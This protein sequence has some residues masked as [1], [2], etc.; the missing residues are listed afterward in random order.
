MIW[1]ANYHLPFSSPGS[2]GSPKEMRRCEKSQVERRVSYPEERT[3]ANL[4]KQTNTETD[5]TNSTRIGRHG[6]HEFQPLDLHRRRRNT[7]GSCNSRRFGRAF[8]RTSALTP[9][10][11]GSIKP[12]PPYVSSS[13]IEHPNSNYTC[14]KLEIKQMNRI[15]TFKGKRDAV[16]MRW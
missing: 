14:S 12:S 8:K 4:E 6:K 11:F 13:G 10:E 1:K 7:W 15:E 5:M 2:G 16:V 3:P 9:Q